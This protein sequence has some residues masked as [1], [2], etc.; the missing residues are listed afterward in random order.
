M[1]FGIIYIYDH[2]ETFEMHCKHTKTCRAYINCVAV[3]CDPS[4]YLSHG[5]A[6]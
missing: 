3:F 1:L 6:S 2:V 5:K 4:N